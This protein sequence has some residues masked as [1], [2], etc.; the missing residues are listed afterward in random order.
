MA[1]ELK[2]YRSRLMEKLTDPSEAKHYINAAWKDSNEMFLEAVKDV[3]QAHQMSKVAKNSG[4]A[5]EAL[6]RSLSKK[7]NPTFETLIAVLK[8]LG[9]EF[10]GVREVVEESVSATPTLVA[11]IRASRPRKI[12]ARSRTSAIGSSGMQLQLAFNFEAVV[13][14]RAALQL[15][16]RL[17]VPAVSVLD[18]PAV[19][20]PPAHV[21]NVLLERNYGYGN[22]AFNPRTSSE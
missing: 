15:T 11:P 19:N 17:N 12:A 6:Y 2:S 3:A 18:H 10:G 13:P 8:V 4:M 7:G 9:L 16:A 20:L 14:Q 22:Q 21:C 5:R 1:I